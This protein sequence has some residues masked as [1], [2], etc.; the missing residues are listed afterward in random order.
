MSLLTICSLH[1]FIYTISIAFLSNIL[2]ILSSYLNNN[3]KVTPTLCSTHEMRKVRMILPYRGLPQNITFRMKL[4]V[5]QTYLR[6]SL[7]YPTA[8]T[9]NHH[10]IS[11][12]FIFLPFD[13]FFF[14]QV[15][16]KN[17]SCYSTLIL[18]F[19]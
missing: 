2:Y 12:L 16:F 6:S 15:E 10:K 7:R 8:R 5:I 19:N 13:P 18:F 3:K 9:K 4:D 1:T 17:I 11:H 14:K